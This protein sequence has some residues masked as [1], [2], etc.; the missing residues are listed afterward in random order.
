MLPLD[1]HCRPTTSLVAELTNCAEN[2]DKSGISLTVYVFFFFSVHYIFTSTS[3]TTLT[4][5]KMIIE[6]TTTAVITTELTI[7]MKIPTEIKMRTIMTA[8]KQR[9][10]E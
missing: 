3:V 1:T 8:T 9:E 7:I 10:R 5:T 6:T 2:T 4:T